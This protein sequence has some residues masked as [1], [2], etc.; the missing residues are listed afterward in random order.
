MP[1]Q[2]FNQG[3]WWS[4]RRMQELQMEQWC[5]LSG[6]LLRHFKQTLTSLPFFFSNVSLK[7]GKIDFLS[8]VVSPWVFSDLTRRSSD[9]ASESLFQSSSSFPSLISSWALFSNSVGL[10]SVLSSSWFLSSTG[11]FI[12]FNSRS[13]PIILVYLHFFLKFLVV[14]LESTALRIVHCS[15]PILN[16]GIGVNFQGV[17]IEKYFT[18]L[19]FFK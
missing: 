6:L 19:A 5:H 15:C 7:I 13:I 8:F 9:S 12:P 11:S 17:S 16:K 2:L 1:T 10:S 14:L 4:I 18:A 3:Q